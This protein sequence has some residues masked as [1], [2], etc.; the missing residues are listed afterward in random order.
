MYLLT[1]VLDDPSKLTQL[2]D[3]WHEVGVQGRSFS[4]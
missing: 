4:P 3:A 1:C 2:L